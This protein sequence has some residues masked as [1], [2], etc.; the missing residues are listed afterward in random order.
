M[1]INRLR[2]FLFLT[3]L[4]VLCAATANADPVTVT[5]NQAQ[6]G[7]SGFVTSYTE[8]GFNFTGNIFLVG[9]T[10]NG[11][12]FLENDSRH[13]TRPNTIR[14]DFGGGAFDFHSADLFYS[15]GANVTG[16]GS[17]FFRGSNG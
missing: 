11:N 14:I 10:L 1:G 13:E 7:S 4:L 3:L 2:L 9:P 15:V 6:T 8:Q 16:S 5:F 17:N 12:V